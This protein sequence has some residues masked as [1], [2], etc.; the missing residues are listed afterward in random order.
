MPSIPN[1]ILI[2]ILSYLPLYNLSTLL[3]VSKEFHSRIIH[4]H[5]LYLYSLQP[6]RRDPFYQYT[7]SKKPIIS[8]TN[9]MTLQELKQNVRMRIQ[10]LQLLDISHQLNQIKHSCRSVEWWKIWEYYWF[11]LKRWFIPLSINN[12]IIWCLLGCWGYSCLLLSTEYF[13]LAITTHLLV[14]A[15][16]IQSNPN[17]FWIL[18]NPVSE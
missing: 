9:L 4:S 18:W 6:L 13:K 5:L 15:Y 14:P 8:E 1:E 12:I 2:D 3:L 16:C 11:A 10:D 7:Y 17:I